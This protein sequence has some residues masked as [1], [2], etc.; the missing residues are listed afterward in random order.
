MRP[1]LTVTVAPGVAVPNTAERAGPRCS[2]IP[3]RKEPLNR[4]RCVSKAGST[5]GQPKLFG[6]QTHGSS[7]LFEGGP[8]CQLPEQLPSAPTVDSAPRLPVGDTCPSSDTYA[9]QPGASPVTPLQMPA[10]DARDASRARVVWR[11]SKKR[12]TSG[13]WRQ[14]I[15]LWH[16]DAGQRAG[17]FSLPDATRIFRQVYPSGRPIEDLFLRPAVSVLLLFATLPECSQ[18]QTAVPGTLRLFSDF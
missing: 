17:F 12:S 8:N 10:A 4:A 14:R 15:A 2:T 7:V 9:T 5:V 3:G 18:N 6:S 13:S 1:S 11:R 16:C